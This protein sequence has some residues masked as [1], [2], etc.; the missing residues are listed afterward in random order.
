V[1]GK[2]RRLL[3]RAG[4][5]QY[6]VIFSDYRRQLASILKGVNQAALVSNGN[7][8]ALHG[9]YFL[10]NFIPRGVKV[11][12]IMI[13]DGEG[14]KSRATV[15]RLY[16]HFLDIGLDRS[17]F[18]IAFGGGVVGD[19]A[20]F[21]A[22]TYMRGTP[23][24]NIPTTLLAMVDASVG[25]KTGINHPRGK[26][27]IGT[28]YQPRAV[29]INP[30]WLNTIG[31]REKVEGLAEIIK[32]GFLS[33]ESLLKRAAEVDLDLLSDKRTIGHLVRLAIQFKADIVERDP[34]DRGPR[35]I[36]NFGH[37][38]AHAIEKVEGYRRYRHGS[39][40]LAGMAGAL[41]L[42]H[43]IKYLS[44]DD[45]KK[46]LSHLRSFV[47]SLP[48]LKKAEEDYILP[49]AVDKKRK[50]GGNR[51]VVLKSIGRPGI[52]IVR[53]E[54]KIIESIGFM[55]EFVNSRGYF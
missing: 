10:D 50:S 36:L 53:S 48:L 52:V 43:A 45:L 3:V 35:M 22:S 23:F 9:E 19:V 32:V 15:R 2:S 4:D 24:I 33:S 1:N 26:N 55:K 18:V 13:G 30:E 41:H 31:R 46:G 51:F 16:D 20:G 54:K 47:R 6:P 29:M 37:T 44:A 7:V 21:A 25:G 42:S 34:Y 11:T 12:P 17:H 38:F 27:L 40:V 49:M 14:H 28:F 8:F 39:A 5:D